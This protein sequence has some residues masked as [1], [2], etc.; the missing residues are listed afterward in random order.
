MQTE[1]NRTTATKL[2]RDTIVN[3]RTRQSADRKQY[4]KFINVILS[5]AR[6]LAVLALGIQGFISRFSATKKSHLKHKLEWK[7]EHGVVDT[8]VVH[9][10]RGVE[11]NRNN[12]KWD[13][14]QQQPHQRFDIN[15]Y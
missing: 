9:V 1:P 3:K 11:N 2:S 13:Q 5:V 7:T 14:K 6:S 12:I 4:N 15:F 10:H 8:L